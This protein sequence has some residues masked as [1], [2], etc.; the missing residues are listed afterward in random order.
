VGLLNTVPDPSG[1]QLV[2]TWTNLGTQQAPAYRVTSVQGPQY[3]VSYAYGTDLNLSSV[4][5]D[6]G[7]APHL[8]RC[9]SQGQYPKRHKTHSGPDKKVSVQPGMR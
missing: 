8:N 3:S 6:P 5:L 2:F 9:S 4:T 7:A 1:R